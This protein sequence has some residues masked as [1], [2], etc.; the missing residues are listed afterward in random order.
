[1]YRKREDEKIHFSR[2]Y[3]EI[4]V[5]GTLNSAKELINL[6]ISNNDVINKFAYL[7]N[8]VSAVTI[9]TLC[10]EWLL[11]YKIQQEGKKIKRIHEL[12]KLFKN[13]R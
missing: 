1:M 11:K 13:I 7:G 8:M 6:A 10:I 4:I 9:T 3:M 5:P 2:E 12:Y